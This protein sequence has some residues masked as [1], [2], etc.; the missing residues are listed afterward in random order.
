MKAHMDLYRVYIQTSDHPHILE[1]IVAGASVEDAKTRALGHVKESNPTKGRTLEA[2]Q[3]NSTV[4]AAKKTGM[5]GA[6][7]VNKMP[8]S[9][10]RQIMRNLEE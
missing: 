1:M 3:S 9:I 7:V 6:L 2:S 8:V 10:Y 4:L 5:R